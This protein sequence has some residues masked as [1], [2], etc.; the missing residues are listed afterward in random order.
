MKVG[1]NG[2]SEEQVDVICD[3]L[4]VVYCHKDSKV[5]LFS[6]LSTTV[7]LYYNLHFQN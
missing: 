3:H 2:L 5:I 1:Y 7:H 6:Y 4:R